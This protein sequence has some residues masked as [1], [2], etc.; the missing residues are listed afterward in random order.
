MAGPEV[1]GSS[2][3]V[4]VI[5]VLDAVFGG[6]YAY[7]CFD[8]GDKERRAI[9]VDPGDGEVI[10]RFLQARGLRLTHVLTTHWH[11]D[12]SGGNRGLVQRTPHP[13]EV[14]CGAADAWAVPCATLAVEHMDVVSAGPL[15]VRC[16]EV[17]GHTRGSICFEVSL[18]DGV[19]PTMPSCLFTGDSV[20][21]GG[22][23]CL[24]E[25]SARLLHGD[26][27]RLFCMLPPDTLIFPGHEYS[28]VL[29]AACARREPGSSAVRDKL[30]CE[31]VEGPVRPLLFVTHCP[32]LCHSWA[33]EQR[34]QSLP[35]VPTRLRDELSYNSWVRI[36]VA[37][38]SGPGNLF[39]EFCA[40][41]SA[42]GDSGARFKQR[43]T[44]TA[45]EKRE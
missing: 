29:L 8:E 40:L 37:E 1:T 28:E 34:R 32:R 6:N 36:A 9:A 26:L 35:T 44:T 16:H 7:V 13:V 3:R 24:F 4:A 30:R 33:R 20:F 14:V 43:T 12:H 42:E 2:L 21:V 17:R 39:A 18:A 5:P 11:W 23:G 19:D 27:S 45:K 15:H 31:R 41:C 38:A 25:R 10:H 22:C